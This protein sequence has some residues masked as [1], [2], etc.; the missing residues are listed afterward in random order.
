MSVRPHAE[1][2]VQAKI[3]SWQR[4]AVE[5]MHSIPGVRSHAA[6]AGDFKVSKGKARQWPEESSHHSQSQ[7]LA[8]V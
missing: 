5:Q 3:R 7:S 8:Y 2:S 4:H 1:R 6:R